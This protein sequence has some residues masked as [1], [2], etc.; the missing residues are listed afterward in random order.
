MDRP[1]GTDTDGADDDRYESNSSGRN[2][3]YVR[4]FPNVGDGQW[5]ISTGGGVQALWAKDGRELFYVANDGTLM[6][7][8]V[9]AGDGAWRVGTP[10]V[11]LKGGYYMGAVIGLSRQYRCLVDGRRFLMIT[12]GGGGDDAAGARNLIV[13]QNWLEA[14]R[15]G[16]PAN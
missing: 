10:T 11:V 3:V 1:W 5:Q 14:L 9:T 6:T 8:P 2:E 7:V 12:V 16:V 13:V 4:P 15:V